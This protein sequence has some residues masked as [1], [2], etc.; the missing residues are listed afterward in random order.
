MQNQQPSK[1]DQSFLNR[2][3]G[4]NWKSMLWILLLWIV[5]LYF[6]KPFGARSSADISY[7]G[8]K[9]YVSQ[10]NVTEITV[11]GQ[12]IT[13]QFKNPVKLENK[14][15]KI[16]KNAPSYKKFHTVM[17]SFGDP[18]LMNMLEQKGVII[19][20][21]EEKGSWFSTLLI[22]V[23]PWLLIIGFFVY[24]NKKFQEKM[25]GSGGIFGF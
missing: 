14:E 4:F 24:S 8:F 12:A 20:A 3:A 25:G 17:P 15:G 5:I 19:H 2:P 1:K 10:G 18:D 13:G 22:G 11:K 9:E 6:F 21:Q 16:P 7:T 23:L